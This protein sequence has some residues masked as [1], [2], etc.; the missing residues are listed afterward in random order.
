MCVF[1]KTLN[2]IP[3]MLQGAAPSGDCVTLTNKCCLPKT[4]MLT[5]KVADAACPRGRWKSD[6]I[7]IVPHQFVAFIIQT[8]HQLSPALHNIKPSKGSDHKK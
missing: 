5:A 1:F 8:G 3:V 6:T 2:Q 4:N 7:Q